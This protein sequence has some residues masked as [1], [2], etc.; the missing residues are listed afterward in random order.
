MEAFALFSF[1][2]RPGVCESPAAIGPFS[3]M[4][5]VYQHPSCK[6]F[7][8]NRVDSAGTGETDID[9]QEAEV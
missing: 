6:M 9:T 8:S 3:S 5:P 4:T 2:V 1:V 7:V